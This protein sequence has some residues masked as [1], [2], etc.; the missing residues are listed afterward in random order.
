[1]SASESR[2]QHRECEGKKTFVFEGLKTFFFFFKFKNCLN[3]LA[4]ILVLLSAAGQ[5]Y[6]PF[7]VGVL[8]TRLS[9]RL[10]SCCLDH[11]KIFTCLSLCFSLCDGVASSPPCSSFLAGGAPAQCHHLLCTGG[12]SSFLP[13][14]IMMW[15]CC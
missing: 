4:P 2:S 13:S 12:F 11:C 5:L 8:E 14:V 3:G 9:P 15:R 6:P 1:M 10:W 7:Q